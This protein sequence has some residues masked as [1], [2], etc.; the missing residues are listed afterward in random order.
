VASRWMRG[1]RGCATRW[2]RGVQQADAKTRGSWILDL[3]PCEQHAQT[4]LFRWDSPF[5]PSDGGYRSR[6]APVLLRSDFLSMRVDERHTSGLLVFG[7]SDTSW[8]A[9]AELFERP[10]V[11]T[12]ERFID[13][14]PTLGSFFSVEKYDDGTCGVD[15]GVLNFEAS[16]LRLGEDRALEYYVP[17]PDRMARIGHAVEMPLPRGKRVF[18]RMHGGE[19]IFC[20]RF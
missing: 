14:S 19:F 1:R 11:E 13:P 7:V 6:M 3:R 16:G 8:S 9:L 10:V 12:R 15:G 4:R 18:L 20:G 5:E 2:F 17:P